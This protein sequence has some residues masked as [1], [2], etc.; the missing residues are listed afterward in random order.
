MTM[1][2]AV[3]LG[4]GAGDVVQIKPRRVGVD[5]HQLAVACGGGEH[6]FEVDG[7]RLAAADEAAGRM[8]DD[9][10]VRIFDARRECGR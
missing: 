6:C 10:D 1:R 9:R 2:D 4:G 7:V 3:A 5:F 8:G